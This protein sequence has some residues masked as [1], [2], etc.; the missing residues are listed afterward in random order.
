[1]AGFMVSAHALERGSSGPGSSA[2]WDH[3]VVSFR[4]QQKIILQSQSLS[5]STAVKFE[6]R[7]LTNPGLTVY[8]NCTLPWQ[9][10][11]D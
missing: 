8:K 4:E 6:T 9:L 11:L 2:A 1:M 3:C 5:Q 7:L 10:N